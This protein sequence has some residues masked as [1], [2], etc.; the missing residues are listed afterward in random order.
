MGTKRTSSILHPHEDETRGGAEQ[1]LIPSIEMTFMEFSER[2]APP[3]NKLTENGTPLHSNIPRAAEENSNQESE[4]GTETSTSAKQVTFCTSPKT[5]KVWSLVKTFK[6]ADP[7]CFDDLWWS[8]E[9]MFH[10]SV[11]DEEDMSLAENKFVSILKLA[12]E[13][14]KKKSS[15]Y[16][17]VKEHIDAVEL[18]FEQLQQVSFARGLESVINPNAART[19]RKH[20]KAV[21][22][23]QLLLAEQGY[24]L[25][26]DL[27]VDFIA[28]ASAKYSHASRVF[29]KKIAQFDKQEADYGEGIVPS[30]N[31]Q[32]I[33]VPPSH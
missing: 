28:M 15:S 25:H 18:N 32:A 20:R 21:L 27:A 24:K 3:Q 8:E 23:A 29:V 33:V 19:V 14:S 9:D 5:G 22:N 2:L 1:P 31:P 4:T 13:T 16:G 10:R 30:D 17:I 26:S 12:Y 6:K 7:K 11:D